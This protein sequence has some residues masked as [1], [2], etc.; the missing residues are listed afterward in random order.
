MR[1]V[2]NKHIVVIGAARSGMAVAALLAGKGA[3]IFV[4]DKNPI[5]DPL[6]DRLNELHIPFE[7]NG[8]SER[9]REGE[10]AV[11]SPGVPTHAPIVQD[12]LQAGKAVYS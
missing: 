2:E 1:H 10:L 12:Y 4:S 5:S 6:K 3:E 7:E 9:A 11:V 8:H